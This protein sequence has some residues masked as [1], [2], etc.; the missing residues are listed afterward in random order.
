MQPHQRFINYS[1][2]CSIYIKSDILNNKKQP[3]VSNTEKIA[4][5]ISGWQLR[6]SEHLAVLLLGGVVGAGDLG[7]LGRLGDVD[8]LPKMLL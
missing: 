1:H 2:H 8:P 5:G 6:S 7:D 3:I 4:D